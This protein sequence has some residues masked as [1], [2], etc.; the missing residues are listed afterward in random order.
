MLN[1]SSK[2]A[3]RNAVDIG[4]TYVAR[5][6]GMGHL[7]LVGINAFPTA[8]VLHRGRGTVFAVMYGA[9]VAQSRSVT[10]TLRQVVGHVGREASARSRQQIR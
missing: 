2:N 6:W 8:L 9:T 1:G 3:T 10:R 5:V 4:E 7:E